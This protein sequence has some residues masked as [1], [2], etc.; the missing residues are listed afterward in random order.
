MKKYRLE[1]YGW[2]QEAVGHS[3]DTNDVDVIKDFLNVEAED[4]LSLR[5]WFDDNNK[6]VYDGDLFNSNKPFWAEEETHFHLFEITDLKQNEL[7]KWLLKDC[8]SH[9]DID[10][11][12]EDLTNYNCWPLDNHNKL[13]YIE[14]SKGG[15]C[16]F[17][18]TSDLEPKPEDFSVISGTIETPDG[19]WEFLDKVFFKGQEL[20]VI[21][22]LDSSGKNVSAYLFTEDDL[23]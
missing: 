11:D 15:L 1:L 6:D 14:E 10:E 22:S 16:Y 21:D 2:G 13:L 5:D 17:E 18:F 12:F 4:I 19:D 7:N 3:I 23:D 20:E 8:T 9:Y